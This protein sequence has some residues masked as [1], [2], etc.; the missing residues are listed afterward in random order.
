MAG[1]GG[2]NCKE[3]Q[4]KETFAVGLTNLAE[5]AFYLISGKGM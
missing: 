1:K 2:K 5:F 3:L 4:T